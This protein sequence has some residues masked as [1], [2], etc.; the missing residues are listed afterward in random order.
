MTEKKL[1]AWEIEFRR[2]VSE[3]VMPRHFA[4][5][6][7]GVPEWDGEDETTDPTYGEV[8]SARMSLRVCG[9]CSCGQYLDEWVEGITDI[10]SLIVFI[11]EDRPE[12]TRARDPFRFRKNADDAKEA[13]ED[14][15][16]KI[17]RDYGVTV[18]VTNECCG[19][20]DGRIT[21]YEDD[22]ESVVQILDE[23]TGKPIPQHCDYPN[24]ECRICNHQNCGF[25]PDCNPGVNDK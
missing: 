3:F 22:N 17:C 2:R 20:S 13:L 19:C 9:P 10:T 8:I 12:P 21:V 23:P 4:H 11:T 18:G 24:L 6:F 7:V 25:C 1:A 16:D 5:G 15:I 14:A